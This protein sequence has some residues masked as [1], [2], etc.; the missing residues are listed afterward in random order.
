MSR[1]SVKEQPSDRLRK[2]LSVGIE[3][4]RA[5]PTGT[6]GVSEE[7]LQEA[8]SE[9]ELR[10][11]VTPKST[12]APE[13]RGVS[14][15]VLK[16]SENSYRVDFK[17]EKLGYMANRRKFGQDLVSRLE[18]VFKTTEDVWQPL[19]HNDSYTCGNPDVSY[20]H[21]VAM[22]KLPATDEVVAKMNELGLNFSSNVLLQAIAEQDP[23]WDYTFE[24]LDLQMGSTKW[25]ATFKMTH[26]D[27][28]AAAAADDVVLDDALE[29]AQVLMDED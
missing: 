14:D 3:A 1:R 21:V 20:Y 11:E 8:A 28:A 5:A 2:V 6:W 10:I 12:S 18:K 7:A 24:R 4:G 25:T 19:W 26:K 15:A 27:K 23:V 22:T 16:V 29:A 17:L 9:W 13:K